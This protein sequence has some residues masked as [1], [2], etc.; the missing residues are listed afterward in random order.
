VTKYERLRALH[1]AAEPLVLVN[2][3]DVASARIVESLGFPAVATTS[4]GI[5]NAMGYPDGEAIPPALMFE[6]VGRIARA[7]AV[8]V[9]ADLEAGY[10]TTIE[11][12]EE[13]ARQ[14]IACGSAGLNLEDGSAN[15]SGPLLDAALQAE[16]V[17]AV[18]RIADALGVALVINARTDAFLHTGDMSRGRRM[19]EALSRARRYLEAGADCIFVPGRLERL[20][21]S[22]L[23]RGINGP[24]NVLANER[25]PPLA[26]LK[27]L[28]VK[29]ISLGSAPMAYAMACFK[30]A[31]LEVRD[32][33]TFDFAGGRIPYAD[34]NALCR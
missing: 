16:R 34:L 2:A 31:A 1:H 23:V 5:A 32:E 12:A 9:T 13:T 28:G 14:A 29:R 26:E 11:R 6:C 27:A 19:E 25:T 7:V 8:P 10:G 24:V 3:W 20:E 33:G 15:E 21:I 17:R 4:A 30:A 18:R 22:Q